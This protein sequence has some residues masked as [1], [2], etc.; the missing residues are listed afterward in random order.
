MKSLNERQKLWYQMYSPEIIEQLPLKDVMSVDYL[1]SFFC[2]HNLVNVQHLCADEIAEYQKRLMSEEQQRIE[3]C[4]VNFI[5]GTV[6]K[7]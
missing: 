3:H 4:E 7:S 5:W 6:N 1:K 2:N